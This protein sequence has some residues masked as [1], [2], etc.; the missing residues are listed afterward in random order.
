MSTHLNAPEEG[1]E[2]PSLEDS[3]SSDGGKRGEGAKER[4]DA[5]F[6]FD[7]DFLVRGDRDE[8]GL[9]KHRHR[10]RPRR[11]ALKVAACVLAVLVVACAGA[12]FVVADSVRGL[13]SQA[14]SALSQLSAVQSAVA[15]HDFESAASS[16]RDLQ[17]TAS[18]LEEGLAA[19]VW[20]LAAGLPAVGSDVEG[21]RA[22]A[23]VLSDASANALVPLTD[24]LRDNPVESLIQNKTIDVQALTGLLATVQQTAPVMQRC[25]D[26]VDALPQMHVEQLSSAAS[27][28]KEKIGEVNGMF[29]AAA[30][31]APIAGGLLGA[32]GDRTYLLVAQNSAELRASGGFPGSVGTLTIKNGE[33]SFGSFQKVYDVLNEDTPATTAITDEE[34]TLFYGYTR[35]TWDYGFNPDFERVGSIWAASYEERSGAHVDGVVSL[36]PSVVQ[37]LLA[38]LGT[39]VT[40]SDGTLVDGTNATKVLEHDLYWKYL[41]DEATVDY[42]TGAWMTDA[43]FSET[44]WR[45]SEEVHNNLTTDTLVK[46][47][48]VLAQSGEDREFMVWMADEEEQGVMES[49]GVTGALDAATQEKP[50]LGVFANIWFGSK[51]GWWFGMETDITGVDAAADGTR[52]YHVST[53]V[54]NYLTPEEYA[55]GGAYII[56]YLADPGYYEPFVYLYAPAGCSVEGVTASN[57]AQ[58]TAAEYKGLQVL[59]T[60]DVSGDF[61]VARPSFPVYPGQSVEVAYDVVVPAGVEGD[62]QVAT[63]PTL[64][65]YR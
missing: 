9:V 40:L 28:A 11:L 48:G 4:D 50:T 45:A 31:V 51:I 17:A 12:G 26:A 64:Q 42:N 32:E 54:S 25:A 46:L 8:S 60:A 14:S 10:R 47:L 24:A 39:S 27:S 34:R 41:S 57:G 56:G 55:T 65:Q 62:L 13:K 59:Y 16:A 36:T 53:T 33:V 2:L 20:D 63:M 44:A 1:P 52:T 23:S 37:R 43:L 22:L 38:S 7:F 5:E 3:P 15:A 58:F 21:A 61:D 49:L 30:E 19:P 35:Y 6:E 18:Q 29:Q